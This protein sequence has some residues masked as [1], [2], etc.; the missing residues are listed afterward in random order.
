[1]R[2]RVDREYYIL[3]EQQH[4]FYGWRR[5]KEGKEV[6]E[7]EGKGEGREKIMT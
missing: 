7:K 1:M 5:I 4:L 3:V 2:I 6:D